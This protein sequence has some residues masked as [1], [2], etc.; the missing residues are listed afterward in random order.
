MV[1]MLSEKKWVVFFAKAPEE[2]SKK[3]DLL[4]KIHDDIIAKFKS[5]LDS[6][7]F[8]WEPY[9]WKHTLLLRFYGGDQVIEDVTKFIKEKL[10]S[11]D[12]PF[13]IDTNYYGEAHEY[14]NKGWEYVAKILHLGSEFAIDLIKREREREKKINEDFR[15]PFAI[16]IDR[17]IHLFLNQ[18]LTRI[19][20]PYCLF[21]LS[22]HRL[23]INILGRNY[24][25]ISQELEKEVYF[26]LFK[27]FKRKIEEFIQKY[28]ASP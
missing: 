9:P 5:K 23:A 14:G 2:L 28:K 10:K 19:Y 17:W 1:M 27:E 21:S 8:L 20:E 6:W 12:L 18:L 16:F 4:I 7:H 13:D 3:E 22:A 26:R 25:K 11:M 24:Y 15:K